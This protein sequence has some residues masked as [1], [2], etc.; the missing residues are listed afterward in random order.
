MT[1]RK[2]SIRPLAGLLAAI[3]LAL[4]CG[5]VTTVSPD[6][7]QPAPTPAGE[8]MPVATPTGEPT[9][10]STQAADS[11]VAVLCD[12][13]SDTHMLTLASELETLDPTADLSDVL[14]RLQAIVASLDAV[15]LG[16][17]A[18]STRDALAGAVT[19]M[20]AATDDPATRTTAVAIAAQML[21]E[22]D[23]QVCSP[24]ER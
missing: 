10:L 17:D 4:G 15:S 12:P 20:E 16:P 24:P 21:R 7:P 23:T 9:A 22:M 1:D 8:T 3:F 5:G 18:L 2:T 11:A 6:S 19:D 14:P 13:Q